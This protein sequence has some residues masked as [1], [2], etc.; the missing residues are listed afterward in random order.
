MISYSPHTPTSGIYFCMA[1]YLKLVS[2]IFTRFL[3]FHWMIA[4][5]ELWKMLFISSK[6]LFSFSRYS[7]VC[8]SVLPF[9][10]LPVGHCFRGWS[11]INLKVHDVINCL[12]KNSI[13]HFVWYLGK[14]KRYDTETLSIDGVSDKEHL[15]RKIME[16]MCSKS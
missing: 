3:F 11:K 13:T 14:E 6:K 2:D 10:F 15:Y 8:I 16:K 5:Q 7:N 4:L 1:W 9:F 12:N